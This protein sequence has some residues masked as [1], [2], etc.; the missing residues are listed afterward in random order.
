[1][2]LGQI[3]LDFICIPY[4][5]KKNVLG[6]INLERNIF[7]NKYL[8]LIT[9]SRTLIIRAQ[10]KGVAKKCHVRYFGYSRFTSDL[11]LVVA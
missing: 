6:A 3:C 8:H 7:F 10:N 1:M 5:I 11:P 2:G 4:K 9:Q